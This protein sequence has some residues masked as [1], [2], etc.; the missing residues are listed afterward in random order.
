LSKKPQPSKPQATSGA[1]HKL[2]HAPVTL[3]FQYIRVEQRYCLSECE[4]AELRGVVDCLRLASG[5]T[6]MQLLAQGGKPGHKSGLAFTRY[7]DHQIT[8]VSRPQ[9]ISPDVRFSSVRAGDGFRIYGFLIEHVFY[10]MWFDRNH[11]IWNP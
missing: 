9:Q 10:V 5:K 1:P 2:I 8:K 6:L 7:P 4:K 11:E 3:S